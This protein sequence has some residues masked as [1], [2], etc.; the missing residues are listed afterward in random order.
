MTHRQVLEGRSAQ[1]RAPSPPEVTQYR[2]LSQQ[3]ALVYKELFID[4]PF[5]S[6]DS[7]VAYSWSTTLGMHDARWY[8][9]VR[10]SSEYFGEIRLA[11]LPAVYGAGQVEGGPR[12]GKGDDEC[13]WRS[14]DSGGCVEVNLE[15]WYV[16]VVVSFTFF[17]RKL[18]EEIHGLSSAE[19]S[20]NMEPYHFKGGI[21]L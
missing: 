1:L 11:L 6:T 15:R 2:L 14:C 12:R 16:F 5:H 13:P 8:S 10:I 21:F 18:D 4:S 9:R 19:S 3:S 17:H 20:L 7:V